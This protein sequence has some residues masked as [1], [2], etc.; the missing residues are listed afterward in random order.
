MIDLNDYG[1]FD[2]TWF[3]LKEPM[4]FKD[5]DGNPAAKVEKF[6]L[7]PADGWNLPAGYTPKDFLLTLLTTMVREPSGSPTRTPTDTDPH[8][9]E[10]STRSQPSPPPEPHQSEPCRGPAP[11]SPDE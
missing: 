5:R 8:P 7:D 3:I 2:G 6:N 4:H 10:T 9:H 1:H 11:A